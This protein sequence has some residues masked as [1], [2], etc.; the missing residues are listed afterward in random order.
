MDFIIQ[1]TVRFI[2]HSSKSSNTSNAFKN[3]KEL[4]HRHF[5]QIP[6]LLVDDPICLSSYL[7]QFSGQGCMLGFRGTVEIFNR[8]HQT[9][10]NCWQFGPN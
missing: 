4:T 3:S 10:T 7:P 2:N 6:S 5:G 9:F 1:G 8:V